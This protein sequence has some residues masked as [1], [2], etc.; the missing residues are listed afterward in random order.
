MSKATFGTRQE[1]KSLEFGMLLHKIAQKGVYEAPTI[2]VSAETG[3]VSVTGGV[4]LF[5][6]TSTDGDNDRSYSVRVEDFSQT[7]SSMSAGQYLFISYTYNSANPAEPVLSA[8]NSPE[9]DMTKIRLGRLVSTGSSST[10]LAFDETSMEMCGPGYSIDNGLIEYLS[11]LRNESPS[12]VFN[13]KFREKVITNSGVQSVPAVTSLSGLDS[14]KAQYIYVNSQGQLAC[15][16]STVPRLGKLVV[17]EKNANGNFELNRF[18]IR[19]EMKGWS[20]EIDPASAAADSKEKAIY[21]DGADNTKIKFNLADG[22][23]I[24][25]LSGLLDAMVSHIGEL[26]RKVDDLTSRLV[27]LEKVNTYL[28]GVITIPANPSGAAS[29]L[30]MSNV[31]IKSTGNVNLKGSLTVDP[32]TS[33]FGTSSNPIHNLYVTQ[34]LYTDSL[35]VTE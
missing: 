25:V 5:N 34:S 35:F 7:I 13:A 24:I 26:E 1:L 32:N 11:Y 29:K 28:A 4:F 16:D 14:S 21:D 9:S 27:Y 15:A 6:D 10:A 31:E 12:P 22:N 20:L 30:E 2:S 8:D 33:S 19:S 3:A 18:P 17:A 23:T